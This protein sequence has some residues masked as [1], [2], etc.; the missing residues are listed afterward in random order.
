MRAALCLLVAGFLLAFLTCVSAADAACILEKNTTL[1]LTVA[2]PRLY[3]PV[4]INSSEGLFLLDTGSERTILTADFASKAHVGMDVHAGR[5]T[6]TGVGGRE[7][8]PV[9][10]AHARRIDVG[11]I[12]FQDW[13]FAVLPPEAGGL[14]KTQHDGVLGMDFLHYFDIDVDLQGSQLTLWRISGCHDIHPE[15][16]GDYDAIPLQH[17]AHQS[18]TIPIFVDNA[19]LNVVFDTGA[20]SLLLTHDAGLKAG[21]TDAMGALDKDT[22]G[23]GF[24]GR[25]LSVVHR[26]KL[27]LVGKGE[28]DNPAIVVETESPRTSYGD[29]LINWRYLK[30]RKFWIS[31][32]TNTLFVQSDGK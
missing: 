8:L 19:F 9:N 26:F 2:G 12:A 1:P 23:R 24:G 27:L 28:F 21:Y 22:G 4:S 15:W 7:T 25:F 10:Q 32:A 16:Q 31:Y 18:V 3:V 17:T 29:G 20:H 30:A 6:I 14:G 11:T 5:G 13:E